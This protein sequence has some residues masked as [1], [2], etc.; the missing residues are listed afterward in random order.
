MSVGLMLATLQQSLTVLWVLKVPVDCQLSACFQE[1]DCLFLSN[2]PPQTDPERTTRGLYV[3]WREFSWS[4][5]IHEVL[6]NVL[7]KLR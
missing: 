5:V 3:E 4:C 2:H 1:M 6:G 7:S